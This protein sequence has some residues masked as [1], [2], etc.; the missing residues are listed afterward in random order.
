MA[1]KVVAKT[2]ETKVDL[3]Q[4]PKKVFVDF[5]KTACIPQKLPATVTAANHHPMK[6]IDLCVSRTFMGNAQ[7]PIAEKL[8]LL[9]ADSTRMASAWLQLTHAYL[10]TWMAMGT[11]FEPNQKREAK[12]KPKGVPTTNV[13]HV[14]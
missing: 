4:V 6:R 14:S 7:I 10:S 1:R 3:E 13:N 9:F 8:T 5:S 12:P 11:L 2:V